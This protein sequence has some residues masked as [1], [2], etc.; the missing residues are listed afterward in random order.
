MN[1]E[2]VNKSSGDDSFAELFEKTQLRDNYLEHGQKIEAVTVKITRDW[3]FLDLGGKTEGYLDRKELADEEGNISIKEGDRIVVYFVSSRDNEKLFTTKIGVGDS[4]RNYMKEVWQN[5]IPIEGAV[6]REVKG[7]FEINLI[8][9]MRGF[10]PYPQVGQHRSEEEKD[11]IGRRMSFRIIEYG[12]QGRSIVLS[13]KIIQEEQKKN[14]EEALKATLREGMIVTGTVVSIKDFGAFLDIGGIE[15]LLPIFEIE[16]DRV[17]DIHDHLF[18]GQELNVA[19]T[20]L[21]LEKNRIRLSLKATLS[22]PWDDIWA[23]YPKGSYHTGTIVTLTEFGAFVKLGPGVDGLIHISKLR[24][25]KRITHPRDVVEKGQL[26]EVKVDKIE[27][28]Q[29]KIYLSIVTIELQEDDTHNSKK[30]ST[31]DYRKYIEK[32]TTSIGSLGDIM[33]KKME[34][35]RG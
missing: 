26:I 16:W 22:D 14:K 27:K 18:I 17:E 13:I 3:I 29:R 15:G 34:R 25:G 8:G 32:S 10:C 6:D 5:G 11:Y 12:N 19:I 4:A 28:E 33:R 30:D 1:D 2:K 9:G 23:K 7:G 20:S 24:W 35:R 31:V 21:D